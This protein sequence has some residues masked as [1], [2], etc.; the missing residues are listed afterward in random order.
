MALDW[1]QEG[2]EVIQLWSLSASAKPTLPL[3]AA[4]FANGNGPHTRC[5][6]TVHSTSAVVKKQ[7]GASYWL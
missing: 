7:T 6:V 3:R 1:L 2:G 4:S 5:Q